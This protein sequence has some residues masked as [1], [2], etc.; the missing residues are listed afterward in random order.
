[1]GVFQ[2][3]MAQFNARQE[4]FAEEVVSQKAKFKRHRQEMNAR[5]EAD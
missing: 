5:E 2:E 1:M 4:S 3:E